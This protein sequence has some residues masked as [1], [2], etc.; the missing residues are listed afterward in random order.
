[1]LRP[2]SGQRHPGGRSGQGTR[3]RHSRVREGQHTAGQRSRAEGQERARAQDAREGRRL[4]LRE[5][6]RGQEVSRGELAAPAA[7]GQSGRCYFHR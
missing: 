7:A 1:M 2:L 6:R 3:L 5:V 4:L